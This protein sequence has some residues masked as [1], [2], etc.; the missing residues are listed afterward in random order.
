VLVLG[1]QMNAVIDFGMTG[2]GDIACDLMAA[3][4]LLSPDARPIFR[5]IIRC[6]DQ[7]WTRGKGWALSF[8]LIALPYYQKS[9]STLAKI[10]LNTINTVIEDE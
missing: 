2:I 9:N 3:W 8:G 7:T 5:K 1:D 6:D 4:T 10:A